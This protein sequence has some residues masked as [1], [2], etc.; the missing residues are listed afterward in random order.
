MLAISE[1]S[2]HVTVSHPEYPFVTPR[3]WDE[4]M[5]DFYQVLFLVACIALAPSESKGREDLTSIGGSV[6]LYEGAP[7]KG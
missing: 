1:Q 4:T 3:A 5:T 2:M 7:Q 6:T